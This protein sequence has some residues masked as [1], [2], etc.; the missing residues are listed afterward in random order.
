MV[1][2]GYGKQRQT[3]CGHLVCAI[4]LKP[5]KTE[6]ILLFKVEQETRSLSTLR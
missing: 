3:T 1:H 4:L 2:S 5:I 6:C